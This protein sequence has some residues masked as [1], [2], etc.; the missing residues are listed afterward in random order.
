MN[1]P[2]KFKMLAFSLA[3]V[4]IVL[5][6]SSFQ[7]R[8]RILAQNELMKIMDDS[9]ESITALQKATLA[10]K[11]IRV[12]LRDYLLDAPRRD[13]YQANVQALIPQLNYFVTQLEEHAP[14]PSIAEEVV[15]L[16]RDLLVF[17]DV[18]GRIL[19]AGA[20]RDFRGATNILLTDCH[21]AADTVINRVI[22][23]ETS[24]ANQKDLAMARY[25]EVA[26][27]GY[28]AT[29][30]TLLLWV[31][32]LLGVILYAVKY[33]VTPITRICS[34]MR[35]LAEGDLTSTY[36][37]RGTDE[38]GQL[39]HAVEATIANLRAT[40]TAAQASSLS[41]AEKAVHISSSIKEVAAGNDSQANITQEISR[42]LE[43]LA[44]A[45]EEIAANAQGAANASANA[46]L[47]A[48][49]GTQKVGNSINSLKTVQESV[50]SLSTVSKQIG[51]I[52]SAIDDI[53]DQ[54]N[55]LALNAAI[56]AAR[57]GEHG[58]G[59]AVVADAVRSLAE[60]SRQST[61]EITKLIAA[62]QGQI[63]QAVNT[64]TQG[65]EG[66]KSAREALENIVT[67]IGNIAGMVEGISAAG[68][69]QAAAAN[70]VAASMENLGAITEE[71]AA[72]SQES[73][74][75]GQQLS[76]L[77]RNLQSVAA[78]FRV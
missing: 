29:I 45:T 23:L 50:L 46:R 62:I 42:T 34:E 31:L 41:V 60:Q 52:V 78:K 67:Q 37:G 63:D 59:F 77:A 33:L 27:Q 43:Q 8:G 56:E 35:R 2:V 25:A 7:L 74:V 1:K 69:E 26:R 40:I 11:R 19:A 64:S 28:N 18:G 32:A 47:A 61:K 39:S 20:A 72:S 57:A 44:A 24:L 53:S 30:A 12:D 48:S 49:E 51:G 36:K 38:F 66:A 16:K 73:A 9:Q 54:T 3:L 15:A 10:F 4:V 70:E 75:A 68:Q 21:P 65:A 14:T 22:A 71:V 5:G 13:H 55:L 76:E 6:F 17:Y 58:R